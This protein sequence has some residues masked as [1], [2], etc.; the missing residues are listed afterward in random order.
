[1]TPTV[2]AAPNVDIEV[3]AKAPDVELPDA[4]ATLDETDGDPEVEPVGAVV[5]LV[6][7]A[8][9]VPITGS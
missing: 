5:P 3:S 6:K 2:T 9:T 7:K 8:G 1:M 4:A